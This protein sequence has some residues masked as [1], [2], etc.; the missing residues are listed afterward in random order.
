MHKGCLRVKAFAATGLP[1]R[2]LLL[3]FCITLAQA[4]TTTQAATISPSV[5]LVLKLVSSTNVK[6]T[7]GIVVSDDGLVLVSADFASVEGEV[8]VLDGGTDIVSN[9]R[10]AKLAGTIS[11]ELALLSVAGLKRPGIKLS[12]LPWGLD[13]ALHL[14]AFPPAEDIARGMPPL[15]L[16]LD[17]RRVGQNVPMSI[18]PETPLP[19]VNGAI[20]DACGQLAGLSLSSG[21]QS[22]DTDKGTQ[23][24]FT[25]KLSRIFTAMGL[26]LPT[27]VCEPAPSELNAPIVV[28]QAETAPV[29]QTTL[30]EDL[31]QATQ[32]QPAD[33]ESPE[34]TGNETD[35]T[36]AAIPAPEQVRQ[37]TAKPVERAPIWRSVP[38]WLPLLV[39]VVLGVFVWKGLYFFRLGKNAPAHSDRPKP[40]HNVQPASDEPVT[41]PLEASVDSNAVKPRSAPVIDFEIPESGTRPQGCDGVLLVEGWLDADTD[42][43][44]FCF[45]NTRDIDIVIGRGDADIAIEHAAIS[46]AHARIQSDGEAMTLSDLGSRNGTFI[47]EVACLQSEVL[48]FNPDDEIYLGDVKMTV[49]VVEQEAQWA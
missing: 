35:V 13:N 49:R 28:S 6:P 37:V 21:T 42:F 15:W 31:P 34:P 38:F 32:I 8:I 14:E 24:L 3:L 2:V 48:Y 10:P 40:A 1:G 5:V 9:G 47:G 4:A 43:R 7:T 16:P 11:G 45:V 12:A 25:E 39:L 27:A 26:N 41:A 23:V 20:I 17:V 18:S 44:R 19:Y 33:L 22:L 30:Q 36:P 29:E 46:R